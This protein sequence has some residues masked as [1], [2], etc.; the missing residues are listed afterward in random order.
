MALSLANLKRVRAKDPPRVLIYS[1]PG[2]GKTTLANEFPNAVFLQS[3]QGEGADNELTTFGLLTDYNAFMEG[4]TALYNDKHEYQTV[5]VDTA[6]KLE[7]LVWAAVCEANKWDSIEQPGYG[8][9][10]IAADVFWK[11]LI[12]GLNALRIERGMDVIIWADSG[13]ARF[14]DPRTT[15]YSGFDVR[16]H[17]RGQAIIED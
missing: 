5:V 15:S 6:D 12:A 3:E 10:Y 17:K 1:P 16:L 7:P 11:D 9:G 14:D 8:K 13:I 4:I 2:M